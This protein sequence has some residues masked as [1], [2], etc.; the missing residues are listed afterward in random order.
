[1]KLNNRQKRT[2]MAGAITF[3]ERYR[4]AKETASRRHGLGTPR[5]RDFM[6]GWEDAERR[7][8]EAHKFGTQRNHK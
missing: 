1:M 4:D 5:Y 3:R 6:Q 7:K 2:Y 8:P